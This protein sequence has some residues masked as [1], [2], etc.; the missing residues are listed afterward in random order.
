[1]LFTFELK[2][3]ILPAKLN[4]TRKHHCQGPLFADSNYI[5]QCCIMNVIQFRL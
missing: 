5:T 3:F 1:V 2:T 4:V